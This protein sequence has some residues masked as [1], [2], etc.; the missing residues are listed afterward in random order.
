LRTQHEGTCILSMVVFASGYISSKSSSNS[1]KEAIATA[2][3]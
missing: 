1:K 2:E 3:K